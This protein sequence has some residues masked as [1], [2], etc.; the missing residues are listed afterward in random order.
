MMKSILTSHDVY[1]AKP[2]MLKPLH[3]ISKTKKQE[4]SQIYT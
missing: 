1:T 3:N 2:S 4:C